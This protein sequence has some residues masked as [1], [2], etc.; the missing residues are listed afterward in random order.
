MQSRTLKRPMGIRLIGLTLIL[1]LVGALVVA[2]L[3]V[4]GDSSDSV[5]R[6]AGQLVPQRS[7]VDDVGDTPLNPAGD[8]NQVAPRTS[9]V[10]DL[11]DTPFNPGNGVLTSRG[12][13]NNTSYGPVSNWRHADSRGD[14]YL[15]YPELHASG[16]Q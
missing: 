2:A 8:A 9:Y 1:A 10:D 12:A 6:A 5:E 13:T 11:G 16:G 14:T 15:H 4:I 3:S 7:H